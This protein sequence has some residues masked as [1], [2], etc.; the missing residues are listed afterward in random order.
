MRTAFGDK[1]QVY[2][3]FTASGKPLAFLEEYIQ[4][5]VIPSYSN[6]HTSVN[7]PSTLTNY[8]R[9]E[10][11]QIIHRCVKATEQ[12]AVIFCGSGSTA[13]INKVVSI[14]KQSNWGTLL[15]HHM[16]NRWGTLEC[17]LCSMSFSSQGNLMV[18]FQTAMHHEK[19]RSTVQQ[20]FPQDINPVVFMS[21]AEHHSNILPWREVGAEIVVIEETSEGLLNLEMLESQLHQYKTSP[22]KI[23]TFVAASNVTGVRNDVQRITTLLHKHGA[24]AFFDYATLGP[25]DEINMNPG[26]DS[27]I[28]AIFLS[29]HKFPGGPGTPGVLVIKKDLLSSEVPSAPGG[30]TVFFVTDKEHRY[31]VNEEREEGGT[32]D[33]IGSIRAGLVFQLKEAIGN[34]VIN[35]REKWLI[36]KANTRLLGNPN[37]VL[38]GHTHLD[39][40]PIISF[41]VRAGNR[42]FHC[43]YI[44]ALL[45]DLF[46]VCC[47]SGC[48]CASPYTQELLGMESDLVR[49]YIGVLSEGYDIFRPGFTRASLPYFYNEEIIDYVLDAIEFVANNAL[50]FLPQYKYDTDTGQFVN[51]SFDTKEGRHSLRKWLHSI[52]YEDGTMKYPETTATKVTDLDAVR[53][54]AEAELNKIKAKRYSGMTLG[55]NEFTIPSKY[56]HL[57]WFVLPSEGL[58]YLQG[59][60][61][62]PFYTTPGPFQPKRY[63]GHAP[64]PVYVPVE[65]PVEVEKP[66][67]LWPKL[68]K[69][70]NKLIGKAIN[71]F[72]MI[73]AGDRILVGLSGGKDSLTLLH[74]LKRFSKVSPVRFE[75]GACTVDPMTP[76]YD[77]SPLK[78]YLKELQIPYFFQSQPLMEMAAECMNKPSICSFCSRMKRGIL[79]NT[80]RREG[81][82]VLALGQHLDD[83]A[84]SLMMSIFHNGSLRTMKAN[85][86][87]TEGDLRVIRPLVYVRERMTKEFAQ[88]V[89]LPVIFENCPGCFAAPTERLRIKMLLATQEQQ[90]PDLFSNMLA[91]MKPIMQP[92]KHAKTEED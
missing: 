64:T 58:R 52:S 71:D 28:D 16:V 6:T 76:E 62:S 31:I 73:Q 87:I 46:G 41:I 68:P 39:R 42:F 27:T 19:L 90:I 18:H 11:R 67:Q 5:T 33:I 17:K 37:I 74:A 79:Y 66:R 54:D 56:E 47:R 21:V 63:E 92:Q 45:N 59:D 22:C 34:D 43:H 53:R 49:Q 32:P 70:L 2:V 12:D 86:V 80:A 10:A 25:Y 7:T 57:R 78:D 26:P 40:L 38:L 14:L 35:Q 51:R 55:E 9:K 36:Q 83:L 85:Y 3:D 61:S 75:V 60:M 89:K 1:P 91:A 81:Y 84:E 4:R 8:F 50:W 24:L 13:A 69:K 48:A 20:Q 23:G 77:P 44:A 82:N 72:S 88:S 29:P 15:T 30:G 65:K